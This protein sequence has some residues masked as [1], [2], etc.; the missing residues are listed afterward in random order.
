MTLDLFTIFCIFLG[1]WI[2]CDWLIS[3]GR[4]RGW[5][6]RLCRSMI[7]QD[8]EKGR[9]VDVSMKNVTMFV[10]MNLVTNAQA[11][12]LLDEFNDQHLSDPA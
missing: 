11:Q 8:T 6:Y 7:R 9:S 1:L 3:R 5:W 12:M 2:L 4:N 10:T